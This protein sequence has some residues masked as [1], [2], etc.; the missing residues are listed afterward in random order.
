M[1]LLIQDIIKSFEI[2]RELGITIISKETHS[3]LEIF[4]VHQPAMSVVCL[5]IYSQMLVQIKHSLAC[6]QDLILT[7]TSMKF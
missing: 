7:L 1:S 6:L 2:K 5:N 4:N 3:Q